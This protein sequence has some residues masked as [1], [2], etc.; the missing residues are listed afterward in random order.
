MGWERES[1]VIDF[2]KYDNKLLPSGD[3]HPVP[4]SSRQHCALF[5]TR[6]MRPPLSVRIPTGSPLTV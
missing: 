5:Y 1:K 2:G 6:C 4:Q 3:T